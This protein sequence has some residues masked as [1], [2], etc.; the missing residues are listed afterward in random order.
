M[1]PY[2]E[3]FKLAKS[4]QFLKDPITKPSFSSRNGRLQ[5]L[6]FLA[7]MKEAPWTCRKH[8]CAEKNGQEKDSEHKMSHS[9]GRGT[10]FPALNSLQ[11]RIQSHSIVEAAEGRM[12]VSE[13]MGDR[14]QEVSADSSCSKKSTTPHST[15]KAVREPH[16]SETARFSEE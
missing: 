2:H 13:G 7:V 10:C 5:S 4:R 12:G 14:Q 16:R 11:P 8:D 6:P 9:L 3:K 1:D 15:A